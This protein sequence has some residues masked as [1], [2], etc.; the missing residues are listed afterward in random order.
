MI[1]YTLQTN[2]FAIIILLIIFNGAQKQVDLSRARDRLFMSI[3]KLNVLILVIDCIS[4]FLYD[5]PGEL[6][7]VAQSAL[8]L[9]FYCMNP[10]PGLLWVLYVYDFIFHDKKNLR[11]IFKIGIIPILINGLLAVVSVWGGY[12]FTISAENHYSRGDWFFIMPAFSFLYTIAAFVVTLINRKRIQRQDFIPLLFFAVPPI[13]GGL[14]QTF[15]Y[16]LV[17]LWP[18][19]TISL[20]IIYVFIQS[21]TMNMDFLTG[22]YNRRVF[23]YH[24]EDW[25][26]WNK[27]SK[28]IA[29]FMMD[30]DHFKEINDTLG[31]QTGDKALIEVSRILR[32]SFRRN[33]F[34]ARLGGDEF[35]AIIEIYDPQEIE[36]VKERLKEHLDSFNLSDKS[37]FQLSISVGSGIFIPEEEESLSHFFHEL[38]KRMY[39]DKKQKKNRRRM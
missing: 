7:H 29:G 34:L 38:D 22:L 3:L 5:V 31:H 13:I 9:V 21:K 12:L 30:L 36:K 4:I 23:D 17:V 25:K 24:L 6:V 18:S 26:R 33:D 39:E 1:A 2:I 27:D 37:G 28:K 32:E 35:A 14:L 19:L 20:L 8:K 16:G 10:I 11:L 15:I